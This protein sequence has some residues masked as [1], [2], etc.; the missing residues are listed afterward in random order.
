MDQSFESGL[1]QALSRTADGAFGVTTGGTIVM[2]NG[3]A[4]TMLGYSAQ[5]AIGRHCC[6]LF[7]GRDDSGHLLCYEGCQVM[8]RVKTGDAIQSFDMQTRNKA[9][10]PVWLNI[11]TLVVSPNGR[12]DPLTL[13]LFRD[14]TATN[15]LNR[16]GGRDSSRQTE[17]EIGR[18]DF[19]PP[20]N[21]SAKE[22][23]FH[24]LVIVSKGRASE[25]GALARYFAD[26]RCEVIVD[27]RVA[28]RRRGHN[29]RVSRERRRDERRSR[30]LETLETDAIFVT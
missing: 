9:G 23:P 28:A 12:G 18:E 29:E 16:G 1:D 11:S 7:A 26:A 2:W 25:H 6:D 3:A 19:G 27:R 30:P 24:C 8:A 4:E 22:L 5:E 15:P 14:V 17:T 13:H 20:P 10:H 21:G